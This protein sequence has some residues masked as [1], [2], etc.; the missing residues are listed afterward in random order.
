MPTIISENPYN[1]VNAHLHSMTQNPQGDLSMWAGI[2]GDIITYLVAE[3]NRN[4]PPNYIAL[5]EQSL[6]IVTENDRGVFPQQKR[7]PDVSV[8]R[9][10]NTDSTIQQI[11]TAGESVRIIQLEDFLNEEDYFWASVVVYQVQ[12]QKS[13]KQLVTRIEII[14]TSNKIGGSGYKSYLRNRHQ[15]LI[16]GTSL[17]EID[18]LHQTASPLLGMPKYPNEEDSHPYTVAITDARPKHNQNHVMIVHVVDVDQALPQ[19]LTIPLA[20]DDFAT[21]NLDTVYQ[22][23]F[24]A[25]KKSIFLDYDD[26]PRNF[27]TYS[28]ADQDRIQAVM[29]RAKEL[30]D[31]K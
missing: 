7:I 24:L 17:I 5:S 18:L 15:A 26:L 21:I 13:L 16:S 25:S 4:L 22:Q 29:K 1:G 14:S 31:A 8:Y 3:L 11:M 28:Q 20:D 12:Q 9:Q 10:S 2:H 6:Q 19:N 30:A 27:E 23:M